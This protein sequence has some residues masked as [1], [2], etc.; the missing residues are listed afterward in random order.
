[1]H[2]NFEKPINCKFKIENTKTKIRKS[3]IYLKP[4]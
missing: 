2:A 3:E 1:M 4:S